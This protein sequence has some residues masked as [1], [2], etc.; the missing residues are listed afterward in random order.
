MSPHRIQTRED[1]ADR[2]PSVIGDNDG[3]LCLSPLNCIPEEADKRYVNK[4]NSPFD[5]ISIN[6]DR[7]QTVHTE[8]LACDG[9]FELE[10]A[11]QTFNSEFKYK[12]RNLYFNLFV[13]YISKMPSTCLYMFVH[14]CTC[15]AHQG[16]MV[17]TTYLAHHYFTNAHKMLLSCEG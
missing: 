15:L 13:N 6:G 9:G 12:Y 17:H 2:A 4:Q 8:I 3:K 16:P 7:P 5:V 1:M 11:E 14:V 10:K